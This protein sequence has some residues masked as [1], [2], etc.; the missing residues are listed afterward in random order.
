MRSQINRRG[1]ARM[2]RAAWALAMLT[3]AV[4]LYEGYNPA[5]A[6]AATAASDARCGAAGVRAQIHYDSGRTLGYCSVPAMFAQLAAQEQPGLVRFALV[7]DADGRW[8]DARRL[9]NYRQMLAACG[10][11]ACA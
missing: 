3:A 2:R 5:G 11:A 6:A 8:Q 7:L 9:H 10:R 4:L 1:R